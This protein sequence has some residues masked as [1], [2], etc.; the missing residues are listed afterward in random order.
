M[1]SQSSKK[2]NWEEN[3]KGKLSHPQIY[4]MIYRMIYRTARKANIEHL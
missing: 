4:R 3:V 1:L 2:R